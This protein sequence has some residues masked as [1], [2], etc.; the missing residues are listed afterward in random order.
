MR[1]FWIAI[2]VAA[3]ALPPLVFTNLYVA[4]DYYLAAVSPAVAALVGLGA[5]W[6]WARLPRRPV[7]IAAAAL[8]GVLVVYAHLE[9]GRTYWLRIHGGDEDPYVMPLARELES[10]TEPDD[11]VAIT[12]LDWMPAYLYYAHRWGHM[13]PPAND[14]FA[15]DLIHDQG[16]RHMVVWEPHEGIE[17]LSRWRWVGA[18]GTKT[19]A[20][21]DTREQLEPASFVATD[22]AAVPSGRT[23]ARDLEVRCGTPLQ[24]PAGE[25]GTWILF[26]SPPS[27]ARIGVDPELAPLP[28]RSAVFVAPSLAEDGRVVVACDAAPSLRIT[29]VV[30]AGL[31]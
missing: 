1:A 25:R 9:L 15:Y 19:Y 17:Y 11:L 13:V 30:S 4:H 26:E 3:V 6:I 22:A 7:V 28:A 27:T 16:Y 12:G 21:A 24:V 31:S 14:P 10:L 5:G 20:I 8:T 18:L 2:V 23:L 29:R